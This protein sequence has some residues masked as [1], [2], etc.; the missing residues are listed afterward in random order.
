VKKVVAG[1][2]CSLASKLKWEFGEQKPE[3]LQ[4]MENSVALSYG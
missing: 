2:R 4:V 3:L 1:K